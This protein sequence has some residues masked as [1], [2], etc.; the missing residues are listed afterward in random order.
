LHSK[1][2]VLRILKVSSIESLFL[3]E[4]EA[5]TIFS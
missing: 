3:A 1:V 4:L 5:E 2:K